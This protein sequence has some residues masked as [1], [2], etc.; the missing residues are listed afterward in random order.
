M[1][2]FLDAD[3]ILDLLLDRKPFNEEISAIFQ[4]SIDHSIDLCVS[5]TTITNLHYIIGRIENKNSANSK[6]K[7]ILKLVSIETIG[8]STI[9]KSIASKFND[10]EDGV[11]YYCALEARHKII[12]T[13]NTKD[14]KESKLAVLTPKEFLSTLSM[15]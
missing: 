9:H 15:S 10:F 3:V 1:K 13:R 2:V 11:Q 14:F 8:E 12:I 6:T 4:L 7:N 5:P